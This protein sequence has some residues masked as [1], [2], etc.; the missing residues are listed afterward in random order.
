MEFRKNQPNVRRDTFLT[1]QAAAPGQLP[2]VSW[3]CPDGHTVDWSSPQRSLM[4]VLG[5]AGLDDPAARY[6]LLLLHA[7]GDAQEFVLPT[8]ARRLPWRLL[9][10]T[11]A[12]APADVF[13]DANGPAFPA[14][15]RVRM[16]HHSLRCYV[17]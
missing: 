13:P 17:A 14:T 8:V 3:F 7:G 15:G 1:G 16:I 4:C 10:D 9:A 12:A 6:V 5:T 2:D 11:A